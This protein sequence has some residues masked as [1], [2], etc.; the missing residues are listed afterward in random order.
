MAEDTNTRIEILE[1]RMDTLEQTYRENAVAAK[2]KLDAVHDTIGH[3]DAFVRNGMSGK[4]TQVA[5]A[6]KILWWLMTVVLL[7]VS[8]IAFSI[9][10]THI[11]ET[12][13]K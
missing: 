7:G 4:I 13:A 9:I 12:V 5:T 3:L 10:R 1:L 6:Q 8:G 11:L 2:E